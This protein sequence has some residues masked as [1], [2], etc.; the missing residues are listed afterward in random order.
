MVNH[1]D[2]VGERRTEKVSTGRRHMSGNTTALEVASVR[3]AIP[4]I[5]EETGAGYGAGSSLARQDPRSGGGPRGAGEVE[6]ATGRT[7]RAAARGARVR[8][9]PEDPKTTRGRS[10]NP[11]PRRTRLV[12]GPVGSQPGVRP[13]SP[14][15]WDTTS[16]ARSGSCG[17]G[18]AGRRTVAPRGRRIPRSGCR[19]PR[20]ACHCAPEVSRESGWFHLAMAV[21]LHPGTTSRPAATRPSPVGRDSGH[22][23]PVRKL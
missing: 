20:P 13:G 10:Q 9:R 5:E 18:A 17:S 21:H 7:V 8:T 2:V 22:P 19:S 6:G 16:P 23:T 11:P 3:V 1:G 12:S 14:Q 15:D 4:L